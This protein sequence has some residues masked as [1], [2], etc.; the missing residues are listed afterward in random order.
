MESLSGGGEGG[1]FCATA[2]SQRA[3]NSLFRVFCEKT[4]FEIL[5]NLT[6][7][8]RDLCVRG[9]LFFFVSRS[10][11]GV[12]FCVKSDVAIDEVVPPCR[13]PTLP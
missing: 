2:P 12:F 10:R 11:V 5:R 9:V 13:G 6:K 1:S 3:P 4:V 7:S 8:Y